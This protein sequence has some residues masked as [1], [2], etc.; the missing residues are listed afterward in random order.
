MKKYG[1]T[2]VEPLTPL[3]VRDVVVNC[4]AQAHCEGSGIAPQDKD[5][6]REYCRQIIVKFFDKTG[7]DFNNPTKETIVK[8]LGEL[9][10][11]S[12][13][14][15]DQEVVKKHYQEIKELIDKL[16]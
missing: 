4:F 3:M 5:I 13:N 12:K 14:F 1:I 15:R 9:A 7:G 6:N 11:F 10:E 16:D 2:L 8:V